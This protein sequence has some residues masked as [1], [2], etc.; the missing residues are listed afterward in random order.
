M[1]TREQKI[2][3]LI[4]HVIDKCMDMDTLILTVADHLEAE[5]STYT[6]GEINEAANEVNLEF[7]EE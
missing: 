7:I 4:N 2:Q 6:D 5:Y 3:M 1:L